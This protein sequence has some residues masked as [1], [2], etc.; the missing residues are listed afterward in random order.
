[1][2]LRIRIERTLPLSPRGVF[3][4]WDL[5]DASATGTYLFDLFRSGS[6]E[7]PWTT[8]QS[9]AANIY[10][11]ADMFLT[12]PSSP[13]LVEDL[14][15]LS[16]VRGIY[17]KVTV[18]DPTGYIT[19]AVS[20][21]WPELSGM[22]R[23]IRRKIYRDETI[24]L[25]KLNGT[26]VAVLKRMHWGTRCTQC[27]D[28]YT[29]ASTRGNCTTCYGTTFEPGYFAPVLTMARRSPLGI[30]VS[31]T[32]HGK[33]ESSTGKVMLLD[34]PS[35]EPDDLLVFLQDNRRFIVN[36][37]QPTEILLHT[38]HQSLV[39]T[40]LARSGIEYRLTVDPLRV[41]ALF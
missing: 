24:M 17:Y 27:Y 11:Y 9:G 19:S 18:T 20:G 30:D 38:V 4:Q 3:L 28:K 8:L 23:N 5:S 2:P 29:R 16:L 41:P 10:N 14:N 1:M 33:T 7:G 34:T 36:K 25:R 37:V 31:V 35:V 6:P 13:Y 21:V 32:E 12:T 40:E 26:K 22:Q 39:V 15:Q